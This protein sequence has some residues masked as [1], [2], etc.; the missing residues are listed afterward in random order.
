MHSERNIQNNELGRLC[1]L[2]FLFIGLALSVLTYVIFSI[3][4][5]I[6][7]YEVSN[8]CKGSNLWEY[9]LVSTI[10]M[11]PNSSVKTDNFTLF[12]ILV[13]IIGIINLCMCIWGG[14][15][16]WDYSCDDLTETN[17]WR[18]G[19]ASFILQLTISLIAVLT[20][21]FML[22]YIYYIEDDSVE[23]PNPINEKMEV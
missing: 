15:E 20:M 21:P 17:L 9:I 16:L 4:Y 14:I 5:L 6:Q 23:N 22:F 3:L 1:C 2:S 19:L 10:L 12:A 13:I 11:F 18:V 8:E 7:D